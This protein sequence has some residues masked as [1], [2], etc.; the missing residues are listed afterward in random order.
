MG[1]LPRACLEPPRLL[2]SVTGAMVCTRQVTVRLHLLGDRP[3]AAA[4]P[5]TVLLGS[6]TG[7]GTARV[8]GTALL[9]DLACSPGRCP[10]SGEAHGPTDVLAS[11]RCHGSWPRTGAQPSGRLTG[12]FAHRQGQATSDRTTGSEHRQ[13]LRNTVRVS[14][15]LPEGTTESNT[16]FTRPR[17]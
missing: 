7:R 16:A 2:F 8:S 14:I 5:L 9:Q 17:H 6:G 4:P 12:A 11:R 3:P 1:K 10:G 13:I 15:F